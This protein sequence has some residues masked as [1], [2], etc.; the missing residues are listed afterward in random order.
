MIGVR[1]PS[2]GSRVVPLDAV[3]CLLAAAALLAADAAHN[4]PVV[5]SA[6]SQ[7]ASTTVDPFLEEDTATPGDDEI[8]AIP[9]AES[10]AQPPPKPKIKP[11]K[12]TDEI[13]G[14]P[15]VKP[16]LK[17]KSA[18]GTDPET[19]PK[20]Q[21][22]R[23]TRE[24]R[25]TAA[26]KLNDDPD[27]LADLDLPNRKSLEPSLPPMKS[28]GLGKPGWRSKALEPP[29]PKDQPADK[30]SGPKSES[31]RFE[32][33]ADPADLSKPLSKIVIEGNKTI[34]TE[35]ITKLLKTREGRSPTSGRLKRTSGR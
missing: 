4:W 11:E 14:G 15:E 35:E 5:C 2:R 24:I 34:K 28:T 27:P 16:E 1:P 31:A 21:A 18:S 30:F 25:K 13:P 7:A 17:P 12:K 6:D 26:P 33:D 19:A 32:P 9:D 29:A 3:R 23:V 22:P 10:P 8:P 20:L